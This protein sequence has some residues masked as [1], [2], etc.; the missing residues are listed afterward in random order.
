MSAKR[1]RGE[2]PIPHHIPEVEF[3]DGSFTPEM[4]AAFKRLDR[5]MEREGYDPRTAEKTRTQAT[6]NTSKRKSKLLNSP[7]K[8]NNNNNNSSLLSS[9]YTASPLKTSSSRKKSKTKNLVSKKRSRPAHQSY[10]QSQTHSQSHSQSHFQSHSRDD[11]DSIDTYSG[12]HA[13]SFSSSD[14]PQLAPLQHT[15][16]NTSG[17]R[18]GTPLAVHD[19]TNDLTDSALIAVQTGKFSSAAAASS[20]GKKGRPVTPREP[21]KLTPAEMEL[22]KVMLP[23]L[24]KLDYIDVEL[25]RRRLGEEKMGA[26]MAETHVNVNV[27]GNDGV[28]GSEIDSL[29]SAPRTRPE[30]SEDEE[31]MFFRPPTPNS[32][33]RSS[34][35]S[36]KS[37]SASP[38]QNEANN[39]NNKPK[40]LMSMAMSKY[41]AQISPIQ[42]RH[43]NNNGPSST[44]STSTKKIDA[45]APTPSS[46]CGRYPRTT[47]LCGMQLDTRGPRVFLSPS[48]P[49]H[50]Y[51]RTYVWLLKIIEEIYDAAWDMESGCATRP[52]GI[53]VPAKERERKELMQTTFLTVEGENISKSI[54]VPGAGKSENDSITFGVTMPSFIAQFFNRRLGTKTLV[55]QTVMDL[56]A[57]VE[58]NRKYPEGEWIIGSL[59]SQNHKHEKS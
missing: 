31:D 39:N 24:E 57:A 41:P 46:M 12:S 15:Q 42:H 53:H 40:S 43:S 11:D 38:I 27:N 28:G 18:L 47:L 58:K 52:G 23:Y 50:A 16:L 17:A 44:L 59:H 45:N 25:S 36:K 1:S 2:S 13:G 26:G 37:T 4:E 56:L 29:D 22:K 19:L 51:S 7:S 33:S 48:C 14:Q 6:S 9:A 10:S 8:S 30:V 20:G 5:M 35:R 54:I 49:Q 21:H 34:K 3:D 55:Q 32:S